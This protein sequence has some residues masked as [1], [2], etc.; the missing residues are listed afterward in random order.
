MDY[1]RYPISELRL[2]KFPD[3]LELFK[4]GKSTSRLKFVQI[5]CSSTHNA[6]DQEIEMP[7][8]IDNLMTSQS[9]TGRRDFSGY[10]M[11]H[12][13]TALA[14]K[15]ILTSVHFRRRLL[16]EEQRTQKDDRFLRGRQIAY[17]TYEYFRATGADEATRNYRI[18]F[19]FRLYFAMYVQE[20]VRTNEP[21]NYSRLKSIVRRHIDQTM[22]A[23][24]FRALNEIVVPT[25]PYEKLYEP[26]M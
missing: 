4:A 16:F 2:G 22:T 26:V 15:K 7:K 8:S 14:L 21:P 3:P 5:Q 13:K 23:R 10:E 1:P 19:S 24:N 20:N 17:M 11:L 6:L 18:L 12:A 25:F 9:I